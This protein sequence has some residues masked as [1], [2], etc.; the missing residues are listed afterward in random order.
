MNWNTIKDHFSF[1]LQEI[2]MK[3]EEHDV[4]TK[5][6]T[7]KV[8]ANIYDPLGIVSPIMAKVKILF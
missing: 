1:N 3:T 6:S 4:V 8:M 2:A 7:L 5:G